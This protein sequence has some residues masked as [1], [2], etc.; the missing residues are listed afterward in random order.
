MSELRKDPILDRWVIIAPDRATRP[1]DHSRPP[2]PE[3]SAGNCPFC[4]G[5]ESLTPAA[6]L[7][8]D[9]Q[10][11][12]FEGESDWL[13]RI[14]PNSF[15][16]L[17][18]AVDRATPPGD[19]TA[20]TGSFQTASGHGVHEVIIESP[21]HVRSISQLDTDQFERIL[22]AW[23]T[24][25][26]QLAR[27]ND[28]AHVSL[29]KNSGEA[30]GASLA[31][32]HSQLLASPFVPPQIAAELD[33]A[34]SFQQQTGRSLW[35]HL[36]QREQSDGRRIVSEGK[37]FSVLCPFASRF[38]AETWIVPHRWQP[39]F[40]AAAAVEI[41]ELAETLRS[42][43]HRLDSAFGRPAFNL[44][45]HTAPLRARHRDAFHWHMEI[46][47]RLTGIAGFEIGSGTWINIVAP[48]DAA[49]RLRDASD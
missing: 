26:S 44:A 49:A 40:R 28:L 11:K 27:R 39:D 18:Q 25:H 46:T 13:V 35:S 24:R 1:F 22:I 38:P 43:L 12:C 30:S 45:V 31:H 15:P 33:A 3:A 14:V 8:L 29:F 17:Q 16:A 20:G 34:A 5:N 7:T 48:E 23:Q 47:P 41:R 9:L 4:R 42:T 21:Q 6:T 2:M 37:H 10:N 36:L 19:S 32:V